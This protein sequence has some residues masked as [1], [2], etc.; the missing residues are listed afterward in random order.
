MNTYPEL[1]LLIDG[2]WITQGRTTQPVVDPAT[3]EVIASLPLATAADID[4][5][6]DAAARAFPAWSRTPAIERAQVLQRI[7]TLIRRD[8]ALLA[9]I[10]TREQGERLPEALQ[11]VRN[12]ADTFVHASSRVSP[13]GRRRC[14]WAVASTP[15]SAWGRWPM[16]AVSGRCANSAVMRS[17]AEPRS[18]AV[19]PCPRSRTA[20]IFG[21]LP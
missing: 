13:R 10:V 2:A 15:R 19:G 3:G 12:S 7:A 9:A 6:A 21:R 11:E 16:H 8:E 4:A 1:G 14:A 18:S 17:S 20:A 5:A